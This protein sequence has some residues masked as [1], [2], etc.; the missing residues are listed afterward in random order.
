MKS[1]GAVGAMLEAAQGM[2]RFHMPG[3]KGRL[4]PYDMTELARTDDL[5]APAHGIA[6]AERLGALA[7]GA[8]HSIM[9]TGGSTAGLLAMLL[10]SVP[11]GGRLILPRGAHHAALS[12]CV[13]GDFE[14]FFA[15]DLIKAIAAHPDAHA[16]LVTRPDYYGH[17]DDLSAVVQAAHAASMRVLVDEAHGAHFPWWIAPLSAGALGADA[18]VQ[19]AHKTLPALTG[20][21]WLHLSAGMDAPRARRILRMVQTS[22]P[23]FPILRSLDEA[24]AWM[25]IHGRDALERL[26]SRLTAL[27]DD[28]AALGGYAPLPTDD[29]TRLVIETRARGYTG[30]AVQT[31]LAAQGV[32]VEMADDARLVLICTVADEPADFDR[33]LAALAALPPRPPLPPAQGFALPPPGERVLSLRQAALSPQRLVPLEQAVGCIAAVGAGLYPPGVPWVLPGE[34]IT[35]DCAQALAALPADRRFGVENGCLI[36]TK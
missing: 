28:I 3:H 10:S 27:R 2:A 35:A 1:L 11:P 13:W 19:S 9:L 4:D 12:A 31:E 7:C 15:D 16:V 22:S 34:I 18:W 8:A 25:D 21:A 20:A 6:E 36:C 17:C 29:P 32:D 30:M 24:R 14:V 5:Y 23:P 26:K 33:L